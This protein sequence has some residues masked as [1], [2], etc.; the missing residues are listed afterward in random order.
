M[1]KGQTALSHEFDFGSH[2]RAQGIK[3]LYK[4]TIETVQ[5]NLGRRCNQMCTHCHVA[6]GPDRREVMPRAVVEQIV[7]LIEASPGVKTVDLTGGAPELHPEFTALIRAVR[8]L[9]RKVIVRSNL[10]VHTEAGMEEMGEFL[11]T[12]GVE[13]TASLPC[14]TES[15]VDQ[16]RG[17]GTF[18]RSIETLTRFN[19]LGYGRPDSK[20][21]LNL[22][23]NPGGPFLPGPQ[24][25]LEQAYKEELGNR[26]GILFNHLYTITN[27]PIN[28]FAEKLAQADQETTYMSMLV[29]TFN[30]KTVDEVMCKTLVSVDWQGKLYDCD[31]NQVLDLPSKLTE[32][33]P[34]SDVFALESLADFKGCPIST[35]P[36]CFGC[37]A[38]AGSSCVGALQ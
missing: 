24:A 28:R 36:H 5:V 27:M 6:A 35:G 10:T 21:V 30:P 22:V 16:Q 14:Y 13:I 26:Y 37:T 4:R 29:D 34:R 18:E 12:Q 1:A 17:D 32:G 11:G 33:R 3:P 9:G 2:L 15:N 7:R 20:L 8:S 38:G 19:R 25:T 23:Y 31:F